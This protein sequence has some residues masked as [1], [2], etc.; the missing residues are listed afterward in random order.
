MNTLRMI[1]AEDI[2]HR[3]VFAY[4]GGVYVAFKVEVVGD[5]VEVETADNGTQLILIP[6]H[7]LVVVLGDV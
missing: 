7:K 1:K 3:L 4:N 5:T 6:V 2:T